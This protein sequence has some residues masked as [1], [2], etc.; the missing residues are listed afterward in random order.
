MFL[1]F[2]LL[3]KTIEKYFNA[4]YPLNEGESKMSSRNKST[5]I[6]IGLYQTQLLFLMSVTP[7]F[8]VV[9]PN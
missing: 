4:I 5:N 2:F 9:M 1:I 8:K 7:I 3:S 6:D